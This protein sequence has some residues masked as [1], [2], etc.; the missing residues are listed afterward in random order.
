MPVP[1]NLDYDRWLGCTPLAPYTENRVHPQGSFD[2]PGWLRIESYCLGMITGWGSH[3]MDVAHWGMGTEYTGPVEIE[4]RAVFPGSGLWNVHGTYHIEAKYANGVTVIVDDKFPNGV[5]FE[6]S[7]GWIFVSR[8]DSGQKGFDASSPAL[9]TASI[10]QDPVQLHRSTNHHLDWIMAIQSGQ[11]CATNPEQAHRSTSAC[12]LGWIAMKLGR[13]VRWNP[14]TEEFLNDSQ[15]NEMRARAERL[16]YG[17]R[18]V[19][20]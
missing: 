9:M 12:I 11:P 3:H 14:Q 13:R 17:S 6:G 16:P 1:P 8:G 19:T 10:D 15:A 7:D 2:R 5:R 20:F 4:G 18:S